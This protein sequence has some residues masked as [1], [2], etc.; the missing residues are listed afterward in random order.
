MVLVQDRQRNWIQFWPSTPNQP[1]L[2]AKCDEFNSHYNKS[3][4][5]WPSIRLFF[6][7]EYA[8]KALTELNALFRAYIWYWK[9]YSAEERTGGAY[10][11]INGI[12]WITDAANLERKKLMT[13]LLLKDKI[14]LK[15]AIFTRFLDL[16]M[17]IHT[18]VVSGN[19][20][21]P[22]YYENAG[23]L[24]HGGHCTL[25]CQFNHHWPE[26]MLTPRKLSL[27]GP[28]EYVYISS[29]WLLV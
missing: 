14:Q 3:A 12:N 18:L 25:E 6:F 29:K 22:T 27:V 11:L 2:H 16:F 23:A 28:H 4:R 5:I 8:V 7:L 10:N 19:F 21:I 26:K 20:S 24:P 15:E 9:K 17:L 13:I 1:N